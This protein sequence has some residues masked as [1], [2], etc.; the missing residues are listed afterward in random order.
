MGCLWR[1]SCSVGLF[2]PLCFSLEDEIFVL[3]YTNI[4]DTVGLSLLPLY[5]DDKLVEKIKR[6]W[7]QRRQLLFL[8]V[9][10]LIILSLISSYNY[11][12]C[13]KTLGTGAA[14]CEQV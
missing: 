2:L 3:M 14:Y 11:T 12:T 10:Q 8:M 5:S 6:L 1:T 7:W 9:F 4:K 13:C